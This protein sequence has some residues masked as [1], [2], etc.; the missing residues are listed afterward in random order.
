MR[1]SHAKS[2]NEAVTFGILVQ[3]LSVTLLHMNMD[4]GKGVYV[5]HEQIPFTLPT[6]YET[7]AHM[8]TFLE[9]V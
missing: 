5:Y 6:T 2:S 1:L 8:D 7:H 3:G 9:L 4:L